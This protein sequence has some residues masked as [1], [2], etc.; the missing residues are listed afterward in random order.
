MSKNLIFIS[1]EVNNFLI[2]KFSF[3]IGENSS[4]INPLWEQFINTSKN[5][6]V[7]KYFSSNKTYINSSFADEFSMVEA[8][9][10]VNEFNIWLI[11]QEF[12]EL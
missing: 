3:M 7:L 4:E 11:Q 5:E 2:E 9:Q 10:L 8:K 1:P 12:E 6:A